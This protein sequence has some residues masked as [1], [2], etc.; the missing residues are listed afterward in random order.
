MKRTLYIW[1]KICAFTLCAL[2][3]L[4]C[5]AYGEEIIDLPPDE[6]ELNETV[7][8]EV[9][10]EPEPEITAGEEASEMTGDEEP[11]EEAG[12][13]E[14]GDT[15]NEP[16]ESAESE[17]APEESGTGEDT[18]NAEIP[19]EVV[20][21]ESAAGES[22]EET[23]AAEPAKEASPRIIT[24]F[25]PLSEEESLCSFKDRPSISEILEILPSSLTVSFQDGGDSESVPV[26][27]KPLVEDYENSDDYYFQFDPVWDEE[28]YALSP[29]ADLSSVPYVGVMVETS[30]AAVMAGYSNEETVFRYLFGVMGLNH[31]AS[32]GV[33]AN[34]RAESNFNPAALGDNGTSFGICQWHATRYTALIDYCEKKGLDYKTLDGQLS[35]LNYELSGT[36]KNSVL[37][38]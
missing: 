34:I 22:P 18:G 19:E 31:A 24:G 29:A 8:G 4:P 32:S 38:S 16:P 12:S 36:Y 3:V 17:K 21:D 30:D 23:D 13:G 9:I 5:V 28:V 14:G 15:G 1:K 37:A 35:Y 11:V 27:W 25:Y 6:T 10:S 7:S 2:L 33:L 20:P 26:S